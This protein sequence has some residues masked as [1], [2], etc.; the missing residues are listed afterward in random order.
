MSS[1]G[2]IFVA[3]DIFV[4]E[5]LIC[6]VGRL[7][8]DIQNGFGLYYFK[9]V[10][11]CVVHCR[12]A[13]RGRSS[14]HVKNLHTCNLQNQPNFADFLSC[15]P[16]SCFP[17]TTLLVAS[18]VEVVVASPNTIPPRQIA[19]CCIVFKPGA[20]WSEVHETN[21]FRRNFPPVL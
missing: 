19:V 2:N 4:L 5:K 17:S 13:W 6:S 14:Q 21:Y 18:T 11:F 9:V 20:C 16:S 15:E 12:L 7:L 8:E 3:M 10:S 1:N